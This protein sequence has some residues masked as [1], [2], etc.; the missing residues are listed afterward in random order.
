VSKGRDL[1]GKLAIVEAGLAEAEFTERGSWIDRCWRRADSSSH[2]WSI[3][4][5]IV[6]RSLRAI[7]CVAARGL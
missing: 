7:Q 5:S 6:S 4:A 3:F 1:F 2:G